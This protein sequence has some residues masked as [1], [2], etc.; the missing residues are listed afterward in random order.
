M[1]SPISTYSPPSSLRRH[2]SMDEVIKP[3]PSLLV[4]R[5]MLTGAVERAEALSREH[6]MRVCILGYRKRLNQVVEA[7][8]QSYQSPGKQKTL[9][10]VPT[11]AQ[12]SSSKAWFTS[13]EMTE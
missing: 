8:V 3:L 13:K 2:H 9:I 6:G 10:T 5:V 1:K 4:A 11:Q 7:S 12:R